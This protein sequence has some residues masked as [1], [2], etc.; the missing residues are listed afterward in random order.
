MYNKKIMQLFVNPN[1]CGLV[2]GAN[3]TCYITHEVYGDIIKM[4]AV[5]D[6]ENIIQDAGFKAFGSPELIAV[7]SVLTDLMKGKSIEQARIIDKDEILQVLGEFP[8]EK[9][10]LLDFA[11]LAVET[12]IADYFDRIAK[13]EKRANK[14]SKKE[15]DSNEVES[16]ED[17]TGYD[18]EIF[19]GEGGAEE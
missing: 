16:L 10:Y 17:F 15:Q 3:A 1:N 8:K 9:M 11:F 5:I 6:E 18:E 19:A 4:Y 2:H 14:K 7:L 13:E 12:S